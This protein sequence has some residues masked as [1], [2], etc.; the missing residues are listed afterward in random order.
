MSNLPNTF[1]TR[2]E[3]L[4]GFIDAA[5]PTFAVIGSPIPLRVRAAVGF[6]SKGSRGKRIGECWSDTRSGDES[7]EIF[8]V[9]TLD[10]PAR[11]AGILTHELIHAAVGLEAGHGKP[12]KTAADLLGLEGKMTATTEGDAWREWALPILADLGPLPHASL[13]ASQAKKQTTR[14][15]KAECPACGFIFRTTNQWFA[16]V[17]WEPRCPDPECGETMQCEGV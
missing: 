6:T 9:P 3:W 8:I 16:L 11:V 13:D 5:R 1:H 2:E 7:F 14:N 10:V 12:F 17:N 15:R 4:N